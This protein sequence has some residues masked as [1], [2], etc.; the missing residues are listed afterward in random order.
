[1]ITP[2]DVSWEKDRL[3]DLA[4]HEGFQILIRNLSHVCEGLAKT[5]LDDGR[6][7][8]SDVHAMMHSN[9]KYWGARAALDEALKCSKELENKRNAKRAT[10]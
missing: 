9:G 2:R 6:K 4:A 7:S 1:M 8:P 5:A 10:T 3:A